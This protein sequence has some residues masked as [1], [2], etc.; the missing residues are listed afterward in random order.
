LY[1]TKQK[2]K[3]NFICIIPARS[4]SK[5]IKNKNIRILGGRPLIYWTIKEALKCKYFSK[6]IVSTDS[7]KIKKISEKYGAECPFLRPKKLSGDRTPSAM[8][9]QHAIKQLNNKNKKSFF[10]YIVLLQPTSPLRKVQDLDK[11]IKIFDKKKNE[12]S[13]LVSVTEVEDNHPARMYYMK[14][15]Y[16][17]KNKLSEKNSGAPRQSLKK[18]FLRNGAIY[19]LKRKNLDKDFIGK[20]P[21]GFVMPKDR[22]INID[23]EFD[24]KIANCVIKKK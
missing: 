10:Q 13:S 2:V 7:L 20:K 1:R 6:V 9:I 12:A 17:L 23:D 11:S 18:M 3:K 15:K 19:I 16:L 8:V 14:D 22:S 21:I 5:G 24:L 4:K